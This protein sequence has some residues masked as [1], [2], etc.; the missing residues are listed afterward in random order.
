MMTTMSKIKQDDPEQSRRFLE[1]AEAER[2][3][4]DVLAAAVKRLAPHRRIDQKKKCSKE[5]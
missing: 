4:K 1:I 2:A 3:D 5:S